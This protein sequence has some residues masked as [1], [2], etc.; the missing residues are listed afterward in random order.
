[1]YVQNN[2]ITAQATVISRVQLR[3]YNNEDNVMFRLARVRRQGFLFYYFIQDSLVSWAR[4][5]IEKR[6]VPAVYDINQNQ[7]I[8][9]SNRWC[10]CIIGFIS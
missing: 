2:N 7:N 6:I 1:M 10:K 4:Q 8:P 5:K 9:L 3:L